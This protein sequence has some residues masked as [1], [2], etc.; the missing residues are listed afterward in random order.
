MQM[1]TFEESG[2]AKQAAE[3]LWL[4]VLSD[5]DNEP[6]HQKFI[7]YCATTN[8]LPLAGKKYK[9]WKDEKGDSPLI[10]KC[11]KRIVVNAQLRYLPDREKGGSAPQKSLSARLFTTMLLLGIGSTLIVVWISIP[12][13]RS[14]ILILI[15]LVLGYVFFKAKRKA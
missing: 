6:L 10:D 7:D 3:E 12:F 1:S 8:Q 4:K 5:F 15:A 9:T 11:V 2:S 13:L 14:F